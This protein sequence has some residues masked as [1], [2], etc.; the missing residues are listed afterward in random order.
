VVELVEQLPCC[1]CCAETIQPCTLGE[2]ELAAQ[3]AAYREL[4][5]DARLIERTPE[6]LA[7]ELGTDVDARRVER[8]IAIER[9]CCP[10]FRIA[11]EP[12]SHRLSISVAHTEHRPA[13][14]AIAAAI[15]V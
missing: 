9:E 15:G 14:A 1:A 8:V 2:R 11:W 10:F 6:R 4:G 12:G 13:L 3:L 5:T 7:V